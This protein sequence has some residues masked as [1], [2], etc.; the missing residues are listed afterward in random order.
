M[1]AHPSAPSPTFASLA[2]TACVDREKYTDVCQPWPAQLETLPIV[3][4]SAY[5][6]SK[7]VNVR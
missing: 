5:N 4:H 1:A 2:K 6:V 3:Y 7:A